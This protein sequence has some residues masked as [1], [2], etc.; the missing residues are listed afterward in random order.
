MPAAM[1]RGEK[2]DPAKTIPGGR[3]GELR[4]LGWAATYLCSPFA[5][6]LTGHTLVVDGGNWL[7][8]SL[9]MPEFEGIREQ[10]GG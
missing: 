3:T 8:R 1:L 2:V 9:R 4:E 10:F 5:A 6:Y 7:R